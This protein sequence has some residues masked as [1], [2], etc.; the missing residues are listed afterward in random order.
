MW[1][2]GLTA[3]HGR[4]AIATLVNMILVRKFELYYQI[5]RQSQKLS[6]TIIWL[7]EQK[8]FT[9]HSIGT[10]NIIRTYDIE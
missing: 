8:D 10:S 2:K 7:L 6:I 1:W 3:V 5:T 9:N 4:L